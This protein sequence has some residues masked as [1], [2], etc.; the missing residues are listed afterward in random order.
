MSEK[1]RADFERS[2]FAYYARRAREQ[3]RLARQAGTKRVAAI[4]YRLVHKYTER[5]LRAQRES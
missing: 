4:H 2:D 1:K 3:V 5:A